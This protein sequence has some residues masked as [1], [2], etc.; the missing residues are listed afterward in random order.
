MPGMVPAAPPAS[1]T[2]VDDD[3][4]EELP[5][6]R[7]PDRLTALQ[8]IEC[9]RPICTE[10]AVSGAVGLKCPDDARIS[11][12][13][14]GVVPPAKVALGVAAGTF[15]AFALGSAL[16]LFGIGFFTLILGYLIGLATGAVARKASGGYRDPTLANFAAG[17]ALLGLVLLPVLDVLTGAHVTA[18]FAFTMLAGLAAAFAAH[19]G[20]MD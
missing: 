10:C 9:E 11:R 12:A 7:H 5:C 19:K 17:A 20:V 1:S 8:C 4:P 14:R 18:H 6:Y 2:D 15:V 16:F 3:D 13:A